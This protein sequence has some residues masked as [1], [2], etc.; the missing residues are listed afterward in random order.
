MQPGSL[1]A[2]LFMASPRSGGEPQGAC[3]SEEAG[4][5]AA[6]LE[7]F[8]ETAP[9][10][11]ATE[12]DTPVSPTPEMAVP[13]QQSSPQPTAA[14]EP[15]MDVPQAEMVPPEERAEPG[16]QDREE[17]GSNKPLPKAGR[18]PRP[19]RTA[20]RT[21]MPHPSLTDVGCAVPLALYEEGK[22]PTASGSTLNQETE[23]DY[24]SILPRTML[25]A[26]QPSVVA[27]PWRQR[28]NPLQPFQAPDGVVPRSFIIPQEP[29][30][31]AQLIGAELPIKAA[32][33]PEEQVVEHT[34]AALGEP[35]PQPEVGK[36]DMAHWPD[37]AL[38]AQPT[39]IP[40]GHGA[41]QWRVT[42]HPEGLEHSPL[43][44][45][46]GE[47]HSDGMDVSEGE[48]TPGLDLRPQTSTSASAGRIAWA[49][50]PGTEDE[51]GLQAPQRLEVEDDS[52]GE[53]DVSQPEEPEAPEAA[54]EAEPVPPKQD[55]TEHDEPV[56]DSAPRSLEQPAVPP[57]PQATAVAAA[58]GRPRPTTAQQAHQP[59]QAPL[60]QQQAAA[61]PDITRPV[62]VGTE[63]VERMTAFLANERG[64]VRI[65][66]KP[67]HLGELKIRV[68]V[69]HGVLAAEFVTE[70]HAVKS[71]IE[72]HLPELR[73]A[74]QNLGTNVAELSVHV[75]TQDQPWHGRQSGERQNWTAGRH[76][77]E[78]GAVEEG[79]VVG[80]YTGH[81]WSQ[82]DLRA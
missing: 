65:Q 36:A 5:F 40:Q 11:A 52:T 32:T 74:L 35:L 56:K 29:G 34:E 7:V 55:K 16:T 4:A 63:L 67:E 58:E 80:A 28:H 76:G 22:L 44:V 50:A 1:L 68:S 12:Q 57:H 18:S 54:E 13:G 46:E 60:A 26:L 25:Q 23:G 49:Q 73:S 15:V 31:K 51:Q 64:E 30:M 42:F 78:K 71:I 14:E 39:H 72:A 38:P 20:V 45:V 24:S 43:T 8:L 21:W 9:G 41:L 69:D 82:I 75:G 81:R 77:A 3:R 33:Q 61:K 53:K 27:G 48:P 19:Q 70:T 6:L 17:S 37:E 59:Q 79:A 10:A 62:E 47:G 2:A 66:L